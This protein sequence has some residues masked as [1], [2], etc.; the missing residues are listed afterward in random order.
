M[1][2]AL[3]VRMVSYFGHPARG[4]SPYATSLADALERND[5]V[6]IE[7]FPIDKAFPGFISPAWTPEVDGTDGVH[8]LKPKTWR[9]CAS[10]E[11]NV[12]HLQYWSF[13]TLP[14]YLRLAKLAKRS[15][16]L[17]A[18]TVHNPKMHESVAILGSIE[19][20]FLGCADLLI[21]HSTQ[22]VRLLSNSLPDTI[23]RKIHHGI[24]AAPEVKRPGSGTSGHS[25][26]FFGNLRPYKGL[27]ILLQAWLV[28]KDEFPHS[29]LVIAGR[30]WAGRSL[31]TKLVSH[32]LFGRASNE[33]SEIEVAAR[34]PANK[35]VLRE[36]YLPDDEI[37]R[38]CLNSRIAVFPYLRFSGQSGAVTRA[39]A[40][41]LPVIVSNTGALPELAVSPFFCIIPGDVD[42]LIE[43]L[44]AALGLT[45]KELE[46]IQLKQLEL[47]RSM[48]WEAAAKDH[49]K[50]FGSLI[51]GTYESS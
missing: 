38:F 4:V 21:T 49:V 48:T 44:R 24:D 34:D 45:D 16:K 33:Y 47:A 31:L 8:Y 35:L 7:R 41:G 26:L 13:A 36:G 28:V 19:R 46:T 22:G 2:M 3:R 18:V 14:F 9:D 29:T 51:S 25:V 11:F 12:L 23:I 17:L 5:D 40:Y 39:T 50:A 20:K 32:V 30:S 1:T 10:G 15:G 43:A 37:D 27:R 42:S 6:V